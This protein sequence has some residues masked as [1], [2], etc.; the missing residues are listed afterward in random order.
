M[1]PPD[2]P[3]SVDEERPVPG[4]RLQPDERAWKT[5]HRR[6]IQRR[7]RAH[8]QR[9]VRSL[10]VVLATPGIEPTLLSAEVARALLDHFLER[11][12]ESLEATVLIGATLGDT[13]D[14][15]T[16]TQPPHA[17]LRERPGAG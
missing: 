10:A 16:E 14:A 8:A 1:V 13:L 12:M 2:V 6:S 15:K 7:R 4:P 9:L 11:P 5:L 17:Q 3:E